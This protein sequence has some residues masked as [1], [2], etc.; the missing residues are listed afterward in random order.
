[1]SI[2]PPIQEL[3]VDRAERQDR[4]GLASYLLYFLS[5]VDAELIRECPRGERMNAIRLGLQTIGGSAIVFIGAYTALL[6][7][8]GAGSG[9]IDA[10]IAALVA[11]IILLLDAGILSSLWHSQGV[12]T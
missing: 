8:V 3:P 10:P 6:R 1:M 2:L 4:T 7:V 9:W 5:G 11:S 12:M